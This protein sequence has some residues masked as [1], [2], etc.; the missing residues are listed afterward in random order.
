[1]PTQQERRADTRARLLAATLDCLVEHGHAGT[2][3]Q[4]V[5]DRAGLSRGALLHHFATKD[6]LLVAAV[7][8][9]AD[10]QVARLRAEA[11][12]GA[13]PV[14]LLRG[15]MS[16]PLF[17]AGLE[18]WQ[19][20]RT[21]PVLRAA[22]LPAERRVGVAVREVLTGLFPGAGPDRAEAEGLLALHRGLALTS[23]L[24][25]DPELERRVV[26]LWIDRV[27]GGG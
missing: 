3:T 6:D 24:R 15:V 5:Q 8:E 9:V 12:P 10:R 1:V 27:M 17:L 26:R 25:A 4:R 20:A 19:A 13:D 2:T 11:V 7:S 21:E 16:G 18:L 14:E 23:V 22:L